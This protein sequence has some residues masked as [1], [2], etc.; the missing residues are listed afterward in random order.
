[1]MYST[2]V[3]LNRDRHAALTLGPSPTGY[4][5]ASK[6]LSV[7]LSAS[8]FFE[9]ARI[10]PIIF[11]VN[12]DKGVKA[13]ALLGLEDGENLFVNEDGKWDAQYIPA[14]FRRYPFV[15]SDDQDGKM[16]ICFDESY[17]GFDIEGGVPLFENGEPTAKT[18]EI[19]SFLQDYFV[20]IQRTAQ[21]GAMLLE[22][23][24]LKQI[25]AQANLVSGQKYT[26]SDMYVVDEQKLA[27]LSDE[28][29]LSM[30]R[31]GMLALVNAHLLS[32]RNLASLVERKTI[33]EQQQ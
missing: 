32:L 12:S 31:S 13:L 1:M 28:D 30:F 20:E 15:T 23:G 11:T 3:A 5:F 16:F 17:D 25:S 8:E 4:Q 7:L 27:S 29:V 24:L 10:Y 18:K 33:K 6:V 21:A 9:A 26:L 22:K 2:P 19:Q 14:Y